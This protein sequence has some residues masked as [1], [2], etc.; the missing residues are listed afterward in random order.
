MN[1]AEFAKSLQEKRRSLIRGQMESNPD[2]AIGKKV[3]FYIVLVLSLLMAMEIVLQLVPYIIYSFPIVM[4]EL[5]RNIWSLA[6]GVL[7]L[8]AAYN[9]GYKAC[10]FLN[11]AGGLLSLLVLYAQGVFS[12]FSSGNIFFSILTAYTTAVRV[13]TVIT[14]IFILANKLCKTYIGTIA[15]IRKEIQN[16][17]RNQ[18]IK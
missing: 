8:I 4:K 13:I 12:Y 17:M 15:D 5:F 9:N 1:N 16:D 2:F 11:L 14:M 3:T 18:Q 10:I 6:F 7:L